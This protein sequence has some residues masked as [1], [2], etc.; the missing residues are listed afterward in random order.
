MES[1]KSIVEVGDSVLDVRHHLLAVEKVLKSDLVKRPGVDVRVDAVL[2][3]GSEKE[4]LAPLPVLA[5]G[6]PEVAGCLDI[7]IGRC[8]LKFLDRRL[9]IKRLVSEVLVRRDHSVVHESLVDLLERFLLSGGRVC[10]IFV[11]G[12]NGES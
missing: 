9:K 7:G 4:S 3:R 5:G 12:H 1:Y 10:G 11:A 8:R 2:G 6:F